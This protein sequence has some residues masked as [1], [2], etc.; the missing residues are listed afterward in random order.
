[1]ADNQSENAP[2][3]DPNQKRK[4]DSLL[5]RFYRTDINK[6]FIAGTLDQLI[7]TG[8]VKRLNG[9]I[10]RQNAKA[11]TA[12]DIFLKEPL[13]D[14][15][16]YQLEPAL[17]IE[18]SL[19]NVTF[20][21]DYLDHINTIDVMGGITD[22]HQ[23]INHQEFY[24][25]EPHIDWDKIVNF[26]HYYWMPFGPETITIYGQQQEIT[27]T[28]KVTLSDEGDN[29]AFL[30]TPDG[31]TRN[32]AITLYRGQTYRFEIDTPTEPFSIKFQRETGTENRYPGIDYAVENGVI[33]L[34]VPLQSPD[35]LYYVSEN[36]ID[37]SGLIKIFDIK[38]NTAIDV[39]NEII[40]K[41]TYTLPSGISLSNGMKIN[42]K[43]R[44]TPSL[45]GEDE[46]YVEGV[47]DRI[48]LIA[49][50]QL[51]I[52]APY[53]KNYE[54]VFDN[55]GFDDLPYNDIIALAERK[56]YITINRASAD[57]NPWS[58]YNRWIHEDVI[59][60]TADHLGQQ[61]VFDQ[62]QRAKRP[63]IEFNANIKLY[64]FGIVPKKDIDLVDDFTNDVFSTIEGKLGYNIDGV[65]LLN[66]HRVLFTADKDPLVKNKIFRVEFV[67]IYDNLTGQDI[68]RIHLIE[69]EDSI[70]LLEETILVKNG[71]NYKSNHLWYTGNK[72]AVGQIKTGQNQ[73]PLFD[74]FDQDEIS[75]TDVDN[76]QGTSFVGNKIFSYK[77]G[78]GPKDL[79]LGFPLTY[80]NINNVGDIV[81]NYDLLQDSFSYKLQADV[82]TELTDNKFLKKYSKLDNKY[83]NGWTKNVLKNV[84]PIVRIY[85]DTN[86]VNNFSIDVYDDKDNLDDLLIKVYINGK[87]VDKSKFTIEDSAVY[88]KV[89]LNSDINDS[90]IVTL[91]CYSKQNKNKNGHYELPINLQNNPLNGNINN[92]TLG[93]VIDHVDSIVDN[94]HTFEG[95]YPG[96]GNLR[97]L[98]NISSYG[99]K[100][101]QHSGSLNLP[102][103]HLNIEN[104][105]IRALD[106]ARNDYGTFKRNFVNHISGLNVELSVK[107]LVD[108]VLS[109]INQGRPKTAPYYFSDML[110]YG[111][112]KKTDFTIQDYRVKKYP[113]ANLFNLNKLSNKSVNI[114]LNDVQLLHE[115]DY[116][117]GTNS[118]VE[119]LTDVKEND[120]LTVYEYES[121]DGCYIPSTPTSMGLYPKF[122]P[123]KYLDTT[124][125]RPQM[126]IQGH[127]GSVILAFDDY[128]DDLILE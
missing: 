119:I 6:K 55:T 117:F 66:G 31:L 77:I 71:I 19:G 81:F 88:K 42:F 10:G 113:L 87:R 98:S 27:S 65:Q 8:T 24:S 25:W 47:G 48:Q 89:V 38:E 83:V 84:Q 45:Y 118:F 75:L 51:E 58:R 44:V 9:F 85:K 102:L 56:D 23:K 16:N 108:L 37:T 36:S 82:I 95:T 76:Y 92:F 124:L 67:A 43:G 1:M 20:F 96:T 33:T 39:E 112:S 69:E 35:V 123:K 17:V 18:D 61:P 21:K 40:N 26:L 100:F 22:N 57:R 13:T 52:V 41:K 14:R 122:E 63:I 94:L 91:K 74:L 70:P 15:Q 128:R 115:R 62:T 106:S 86:L 97:D 59:Q 110:G 104:N 78:T 54:V 114:Y 116:I 111:A 29:R 105:L 64:N 103:Y 127:D 32:P 46:F 126:V 11:V 49:E 7:Q 80:K 125:I 53:S 79:E 120:V 93:E 2:P 99:I 121:T 60:K 109:E 90:D 72:W 30:F 68:R 101:V 12:K 73:S 28:F 3:I 34:T 4:T 107:D 5:P 50:K